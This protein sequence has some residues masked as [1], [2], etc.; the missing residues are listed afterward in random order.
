MV[1]QTK[2]LLSIVKSTAMKRRDSVTF[3][4]VLL[5]VVQVIACIVIMDQRF[6]LSMSQTWTNRSFVM[7]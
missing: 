5:L 6:N 3:S 7:P 1:S 4:E 2:K